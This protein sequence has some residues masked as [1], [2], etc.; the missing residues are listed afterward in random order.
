MSIHE[1]IFVNCGCRPSGHRRG[2]RGDSARLRY[3]P[4]P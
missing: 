3:D 2:R 4:L 1:I